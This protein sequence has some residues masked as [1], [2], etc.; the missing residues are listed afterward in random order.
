MEIHHLSPRSIINAQ[1]EE[2]VPR[3]RSATDS[4]LDNNYHLT[5]TINQDHV[6]KV[7]KS[8]SPE[9]KVLEEYLS[10]LSSMSSQTCSV[11]PA[12]R[13]YAGISMPGLSHDGSRLKVNQDRLIMFE[14]Q[15]TQSFICACLDGHGMNGHVISDIFKREI[16]QRLCNHALFLS[17]IE[18]AI[19]DVLAAI[20]Y[21]IFQQE[22]HLADFSGTTMTLA[23]IRHSRV[24]IANI[25]DSRIILGKKRRFLQHSQR[26][27]LHSFPLPTASSATFSPVYSE[28]KSLSNT[29]I[30]GMVDAFP[31]SVD[32]KPHVP[33]EYARILAAGGRVFSVRYEDGM[34]GPPRVWLGHANLPGLAMSRSLGDFVVHTAGVISRPDIIQYDLQTHED[35]YLVVGTDGLWDFMANEEVVSMVHHHAEAPPHEAVRHLVEAAR[36]KFFSKRAISETDNKNA[37]LDDTTVCVVHLHHGQHPIA[38][39][40]ADVNNCSL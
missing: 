30:K 34:I 15:D 29:Q 19:C 10:F 35:C 26:R 24:T 40:S 38:K 9:G 21:E 27:R 39:N 2:V 11:A 14:D 28:T 22:P 7:S 23:V 13:S 4:S 16:E 33:S 6:S 8:F 12:V 3:K 37:V 17:N 20:E 25:G 18:H 1:N 31:L 5:S 36:S 32:H